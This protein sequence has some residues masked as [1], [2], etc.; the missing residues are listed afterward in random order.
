MSSNSI[1]TL[2]HSFTIVAAQRYANVRVLSQ[3]NGIGGLGQGKEDEKWLIPWAVYVII[4]GGLV[5]LCARTVWVMRGQV[6]QLE[7]EWTKEKGKGVARPSK[8]VPKEDAFGDI[9]LQPIQSAREDDRLVSI[10]G[11]SFGRIGAGKGKGKETQGEE[12]E[13]E[14][15]D[16]ETLGFRPTYEFKPPNPPFANPQLHADT[17][18][19]DCNPF[20]EGSSKDSPFFWSPS[21]EKRLRPSALPVSFLPDHPRESQNVFLHT[22]CQDWGLGSGNNVPGEDNQETS[23]VPLSGRTALPERR[24]SWAQEEEQKFQAVKRWQDQRRPQ[25]PSGPPNL[26]SGIELDK[27]YSFIDGLPY[28]VLPL[29]SRRHHHHRS[30]SKPSTPTTTRANDTSER[31]NNYIFDMSLPSSSFATP[32]RTPVQRPPPTIGRPRRPPFLLPPGGKTPANILNRFHPAML[33]TPPISPHSNSSGAFTVTTTPRS[34]AR[35]PPLLS[36]Y[37]SSPSLV[38]PPPLPLPR[39][40]SPPTRTLSSRFP[41]LG[42]PP[43]SPVPSS[44]TTTTTTTSPPPPPPRTPSSSYPILCTPFTS[45]HHHHHHHHPP[46][47]SP[48]HYRSSS[49]NSGDHQPPHRI[50]TSSTGYATNPAKPAGGRKGKGAGVGVGVGVGAGRRTTSAKRRSYRRLD[51]GLGTVSEGA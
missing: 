3:A 45:P 51:T 22:N 50:P 21:W 43:P 38:T 37:H 6:S 27:P 1:V 20:G 13:V 9:E 44:P 35:P 36:P 40:A 46:H 42:S 47:H 10:D 4:Q 8:D 23:A 26:P 48:H 28:P 12:E 30:A 24:N 18:W 33:H 19:E 11:T 34:S 7:K 5:I 31:E 41:K 32:P 25:T 29:S 17:V 2:G 39:P 49:S 15:P 16:W 14:E